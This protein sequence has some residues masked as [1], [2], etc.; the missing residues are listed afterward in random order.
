MFTYR[1]STF[2][3]SGTGES[4]RLIGTRVSPEMFGILGVAPLVGRALTA[5]DDRANAKVVVI[6]HRLWTRVFGRD[7]AVVGRTLSLDRQ[8]YTIVGV[9][10]DRFEFPPRG[11]ENNG[12]P[13]ALYLPIAF[14]PF[15]R[16]GFGGMYNNSVVA[17]LRPGVSVEQA[18]AEL[19]ILV[20]TLV[21]RYP[22]ILTGFAAE[23][24]LPAWP[25][26]DEVV[27]R[28]RRMILV[29]MGAVG[30]VLLIGCADVA[31]LMLTRAGSRQRE[32]AIRSALGAS[33]ARVVRQLVTE[34]FVLS[35]IGGALGLL[36][37]YWTVQLLL[38]MAG[39]A[40]PRAES[41]DVDARVVGFTVALALLT[42]LIFGVVPALR[43]ALASTFDAL[44]EGRSATAGRARHRL[45][46]SLVVAQ[47]A[48]ALMLSVGAGLLVRSFVR[49]LGSNPG[50]RP[51]HVV[52]ASVNLPEGRYAEGRAGEGVLSAGTRRRARDSRRDRRVHRQSI[53]RCKSASAGRSRPIRPR[54]AIPPR[55]RVIAATWTAGQHFEA[56][57]I[58]LKRG[59]FFTDADGRTGGQVVI[60]SEMLARRLWPDEDPIGR[61]IK[62]GLEVSRSPWMTVV[63]VVGDVTQ[64][65]LG[66]ETVAQ[67]YEPLW[68]LPDSPH[69]SSASI[70]R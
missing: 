21:E 17:R 35:T 31:N 14:S 23:L 48:L 69:R 57:G 33:P 64:G 59:R 41:I 30:I 19:G 65:A 55:S 67:T 13:A 38:S 4:E 44:K 34:G 12:E 20:K 29:L 54:S 16:Q 8:P 56:L 37:A 61:Q 9:M 63:G 18:R 36:L 66:T 58:P 15:E 62:W 24:S 6:S 32:I 1:S 52:T 45:L 47:F 42:P 43:T 28:S 50:F 22:P 5:E 68:Q 40:L 11:A 10:S 70:A 51:E 7:P 25:F 53:A 27:G 60:L 49:L 3:L 2:E 46:G 26:Q 39:D